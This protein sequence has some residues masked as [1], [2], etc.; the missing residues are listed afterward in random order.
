MYKKWTVINYRI[1]MWFMLLVLISE[2]FGSYCTVDTQLSKNKQS[3]R[4][5]QRGNVYVLMFRDVLLPP[6]RP[7]PFVLCNN[8][9]L[10]TQE[11]TPTTLKKKKKKKRK[12]TPLGTSMALD[13]S[14]RRDDWLRQHTPPPPSRSTISLYSRRMVSLII[15][16]LGDSTWYKCLV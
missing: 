6:I 12:K 13:W 3:R 14:Y 15:H 4:R 7:G 10:M 5:L 2:Y 9:Q 16:R 8:N 1:R 11:P